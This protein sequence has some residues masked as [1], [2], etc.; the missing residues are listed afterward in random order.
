M[1]GTVAHVETLRL[2][3]EERTLIS[4]LATDVAKRELS[5]KMTAH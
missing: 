3:A 2:E 5:V 4:R 1:K